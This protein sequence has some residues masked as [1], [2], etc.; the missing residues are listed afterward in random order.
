MAVLQPPAGNQLVTVR[1]RRYVVSEVR[2]SQLEPDSLRP[3]APPQHHVTLQCVED[4]AM[5]EE[6]EVIWEIEPGTR[7][8]EALQ[9]PA[10]TGSTSRGRWMPFSTPCAG[11]SSVMNREVV[12]HIELLEREVE[13]IP[14]MTPVSAGGVRGGLLGL[15]GLGAEIWQNVDPVEYVRCLRDEWDAP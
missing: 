2:P 6:L 10:P 12:Q 8:H 5:G 7:V 3:L 1:Q 14:L 4:D 9:L 13:Q 11:Y 15:Q